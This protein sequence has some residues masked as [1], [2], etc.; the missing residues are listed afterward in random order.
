MIWYRILAFLRGYLVL[1]V[2]GN[3]L[4]K[5]VNLAMAEGIYL[6]DLQR[7]GK[8]LIR[9]KVGVSGLRALRP[10][11]QRTK[12]RARIRRRR[13]LPFCCKRSCAAGSGWL[14]CF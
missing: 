6:W 3:S 7:P 9:V 12:S 5:L 10:L 13:G 2:Y 11:L 1:T 8:D 14:A 4:V